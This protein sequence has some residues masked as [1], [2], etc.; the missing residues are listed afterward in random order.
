MIKIQLTLYF[1]ITT[2]VMSQLVH[3]DFAKMH[4]WLRTINISPEALQLGQV[5]QGKHRAKVADENG[6]DVFDVDQIKLRHAE[7]EW[8]VQI[9]AVV[10]VNGGV[11]GRA[12]RE[13]K[14]G[15]GVEALVGHQQLRKEEL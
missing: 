2:N 10:E 3:Q 13:A 9:R 7:L 6:V 5:G 11:E 4:N 12:V 8:R 1:L 15:H 14:V